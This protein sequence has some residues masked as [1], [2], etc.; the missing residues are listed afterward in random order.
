[1][2]RSG[3]CLPAACNSVLD[4]HEQG[5]GKNA[6]T[7]LACWTSTTWAGLV[8]RLSPAQQVTVNLQEVLK[9]LPG[10]CL[11]VITGNNAQPELS[12]MGAVGP[13]GGVDN[14]TY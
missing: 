4:S 10:T 14:I 7:P 13:L 6:G 3:G 11:A 8:S 5:L 9:K 1:M 2:R 12:T